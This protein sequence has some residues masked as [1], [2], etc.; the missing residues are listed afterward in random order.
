MRAGAGRQTQEVAGGRLATSAQPPR[1]TRS[2]AAQVSCQHALYPIRPIVPLDT[3]G[4]L[5]EGLRCST[6]SRPLP[7]WI[8][9]RP[10]H[11]RRTP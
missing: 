5:R 6:A 7:E 9:Q 11:A 8:L 2:P 1:A 4:A 10:R 3:P